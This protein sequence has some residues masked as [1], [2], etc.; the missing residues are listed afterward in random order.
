[1]LPWVWQF[2]RAFVRLPDLRLH[3]LR[4]A[5]SAIAL[6]ASFFAIAR[7]PL[8]LFTAISFTRPILITMAAAWILKEVI[9]RD[10]WLAAG[11]GLV[12]VII[13]V[14]PANLSGG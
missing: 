11:V 2:R 13:A 3:A 6:T 7:L 12:G 14:E 5:F 10:R 1:M 9:E 4:V 8:A